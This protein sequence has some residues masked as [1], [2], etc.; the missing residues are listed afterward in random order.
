MTTL[1][2]TRHVLRKVESE[3]RDLEDRY[4]EVGEYL[5]G[6]SCHVIALRRQLEELAAVLRSHFDN[7]DQEGRFDDIVITAPW[8]AH[9]AGEL[10]EERQEL[11]I[12]LDYLESQLEFAA[13]T[14]SDICV[15]CREFRDFIR[16]CRAHESR[17]RALAIEER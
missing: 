8:L 4:I 10:L 17:E 5:D 3:H 16:A 6:P 13:E 1:T 11:L 2:S 7:E 12:R 14:A 9:R 15:L